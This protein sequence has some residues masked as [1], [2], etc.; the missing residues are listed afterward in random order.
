MI[1]LS[2]DVICIHVAQGASKLREVKVGDA[3]KNPGLEP[4]PPSSGGD[5]ALRQNIFSELLLYHL[6]VFK[7]LALQGCIKSHLKGLILEQLYL[8]LKKA[9]VLNIQLNS[10]L[11]RQFFSSQKTLISIMFIRFPLGLFLPFPHSTGAR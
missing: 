4:G 6:A 10:F 2:H 5:W 9:C 7:S 3:E 1:G 8:A 11:F